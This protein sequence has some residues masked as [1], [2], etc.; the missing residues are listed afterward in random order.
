MET[1]RFVMTSTFY[2]PHHLGGDAVHVKGLSEE[3]AKLGHE[4]H[5]M[6]SKD[7]YRL[8]RKDDPKPDSSDVHVHSL[9]SPY[10]RLT[11]L[12]AYCFGNSRFI[13]RSYENLLKEVKPDIVHHHN[14]SLLG[15]GLLKKTGDYLQ[16]YTAHD[17]WLICQRNDMMRNNIPCVG[18]HCKSCAISSKRFPQLWRKRL[19]VGHIDRL[20][21]AS[22]YM[23]GTLKKL[24]LK[25]VILPNFSIEPPKTIPDIQDT[26]FFLYL[27]VIDSHKGIR[28]LVNA[29][30]ASKNKLIIIGRGPMAGW[31]ERTIRTRKLDPRVRHLGWKTDDR[32]QYLKKAN[33]IIIPSTGRENHPLVALEALSVGTPVICSD[34]GGTKEIASLLSNELVIPIGEL[35]ARLQDVARPD[36]PEDKVI[37]A[38]KENFTVKRYL[39]RYLALIME[40]RTA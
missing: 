12:K 16:L 33:A 2:P 35:E 31:V 18:D 36:I 1:L 38:F 4:V 40:H 9:R 29:F 37:K 39:D 20:I 32:W 27:G 17:H 24:N 5:V 21:C 8:K 7:A 25:T 34:M 15:H 10:G 22:N 30:S 3:L 11:P 28:E 19:D 26:D 6:H 13:L 23:A 14:I